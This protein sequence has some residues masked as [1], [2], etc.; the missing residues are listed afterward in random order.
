MAKIEF[1]TK[2]RGNFLDVPVFQRKHCDMAAFRVHPKYGSFANSDMFSNALARIRQDVIGSE[3]RNY[4]KLD[5]L[6]ANV[7]V[8]QTGF[9]A[10]V[11]I[12][13]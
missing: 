9:L 5:S 2:I 8:D 13:V 4:L 12:E 7:S 1:K 3:Y 10:M 11:T 6:P